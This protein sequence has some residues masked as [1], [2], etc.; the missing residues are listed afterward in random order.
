MMRLLLVLVFWSFLA[1]AQNLEVLR[2]SSPAKVRPGD[3]A[4]HVWQVANRASSALT[5]R[6]ALEFPEGW[7]ALGLPDSLSLGPG[8][9][10]Y[11]FLTLYVPRTAKSGAYRVRLF[12][13]WDS[14]E[15]VSEAT[16]EVETVAA[17]DLFPPPSQSA[18]PGESLT[19]TLRAVN[20]GNS[21]DHITI[22]VRTGAGWKTRVSPPQLPLS[23]GEAG[24]A[25]V[26]VD[27]PEDAGVGREVVMAIARSGI[28]SEVEAHTAWYVEILPPGPERVPVQLFAELSLQGLGHLSYDF[29]AGTGNSFLGFSGRGMVL[30]GALEISARWAG[31]W[32]PQPYRFLHFQTVYVTD[33]LEMQAGRVSLSFDSLLSGLGFWGLGM[34]L[35]LKDVQLGFGSG[36]EGTVARAGG[37]ASVRSNWGEVGGAY[38]EEQ[39]SL[40]SQAGTVWIAL[41]ALEGVEFRMDGGAARVAGLTRFAGM[42]S[43]T[44]EIPDLFFLEARGYAVDPGFPALVRDR[45]GVLLS[46]RL[47]AEK[48]GF[49]FTCHWEQ[50]NL[51]D[52][53]PFTRL[54]QGVE[55]GWD[56]FPEEWP[57]RFGFLVSLRRT[58]DQNFPAALDER[59]ARVEGRASFSY[60]GF[61]LGVQGAYTR[62]QDLASNRIWTTREFQ[63]RLNL[64]I[65]Q[66]IL[67]SANF[68]QLLLSA[69]EE[70][71]LQDE[72]ELTLSVGERFRLSWEYGRAG[73]MARVELSLCPAQPLVLKFGAESRWQEE[74]VPL[75]FGVFLD[76][77]YAFSWAPPFLPVFGVLSGA[78]FAD[79]NGNGALDPGE[80][81]VPGVVL[82]LG[83][84]LVSSGKDGEFL[85]PGRPPGDYQVRIVHVPAGFGISIRELSASLGL[86]KKTRV[87]IPLVPLAE[88][89][90]VVF[91]DSDGDRIQGPG[92][93]G[94][95]RAY[96]RIVAEDGKAVEVLSGPQG[97]FG[98]A[99]LL[100]GKY[101]VELVLESLPPRHDPTTPEA[102]ELSL[103]PGEKKEVMFGVRERPRPV[104]M[105]QPPLAEFTWIP[106]VPKPGESVLF[107]GSL[108]QAFNGEIVSYVWDFNDDGV[109]DA[110][111]MRATWIFPEP[112]FYLV[113]LLIIDSTGLTGQTQYL[114]QVRP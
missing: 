99:E 79:L 34:H 102:V 90:G 22:E 46:G 71:K 101:R 83:D 2:L 96:V 27:I 60:Q 43:L 29:L 92:E 105:I 72:T 11:L 100:P 54:W 31:P 50:D 68:H 59:V 25:H 32:A 40:H 74:G 106:A 69:P 44:W 13:R 87:L 8:E 110:E 76:F 42:M 112:G 107:D 98:W 73:G 52:L 20:R 61:T 56:L 26:I 95:S 75:R 91:L 39:D 5:V 84:L 16:V 57:L 108:S 38:R 33:T 97:R 114:L 70:E 63:E 35:V 64:E 47:G 77:S 51:R 58:A 36:W 12:L 111:G 3:F 6:A 65:S 9:E 94:L 23:P 93:P 7:E 37:S 104:I 113:T 62:F 10:D 17:L 89:Q 15:T 19:F 1:F 78:V 82:G 67:A 53:A 30:D 86:G 24:E 4:A 49:R 88:I 41:R 55:A 45:A 28:A 80:P 103:A 48:A 66:Q 21:L 18:Q 85:F 109:M 14:E 81:G